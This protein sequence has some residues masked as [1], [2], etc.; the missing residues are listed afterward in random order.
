MP[1][2][3]QRQG[4]EDVTGFQPT[5]PGDGDTQGH[6]PHLIRVVGIGS[7]GQRNPQILGLAAMDV[8]EVEPLKIGVDLLTL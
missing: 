8:V 3:F 7:D 4:I 2:F 6:H 5:S 1:T